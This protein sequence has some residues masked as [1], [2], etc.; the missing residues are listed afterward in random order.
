[1]APTISSHHVGVVVRCGSSRRMTRLKTSIIATPTPVKT[2]RLMNST[3]PECGPATEKNQLIGMDAIIANPPQLVVT[4]AAQN[5]LPT[6]SLEPERLLRMYNA[7]SGIPHANPA[8]SV[9]ASPLWTTSL[10]W[11]SSPIVMPYVV[12]P[13]MAVPISD[14]HTHQR[15]CTWP[16]FHAA[17]NSSGVRRACPT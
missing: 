1:M 17:A 6:D 3:K 8:A 2:V 7:G 13:R 4:R 14:S 9:Q 15:Y 10:A 11:P 12:V 5:V 16:S